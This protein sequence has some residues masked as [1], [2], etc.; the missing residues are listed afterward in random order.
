[1]LT[2]SPRA[3]VAPTVAVL[4]GAALAASSA[5][6]QQARTLTFDG[7]APARRD[8]RQ[9]D[10]RP[11]GPSNGD[12]VIAAFTLRSGGRIAGRAHVTCLIIDRAYEGQDCQIVLVLRDGML[13]AAGGGLDKRLPGQAR[14]PDELTDE[15]ALTGGTGAYEGASGTLSTTARRDD[16]LDV[17]V[18]Y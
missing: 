6:G 4:A 5:G 12:Q 15:Y 18:S 3:L 11:R 7:S 8:I 13:T 10:L 1:M 16:S 17:R 9:V 14:D 2:I